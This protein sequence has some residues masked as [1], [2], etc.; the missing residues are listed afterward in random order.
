VKRVAV[1]VA[2]VYFIAMTVAT[3]FPGLTLAN[4]IRPFILGLPFTFAWFTF[5]IVGALIVLSFLYWSEGR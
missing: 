1:V 4:R 5:W 3:T 2:V